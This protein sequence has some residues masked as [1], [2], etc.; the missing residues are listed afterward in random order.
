MNYTTP[1]R[2]GEKV[3][4]LGCGGKKLPGSTGVDFCEESD[5]DVIWDLD[6][7]PYPF[8]DNS[9]DRV[10]AEHVLEHVNNYLPAIE[11][12][13]RIL[14]PGGVLDVEVPYF[15][16]VFAFSD[17]THR[18][19]YTSRSFDYFVRGT[20]VFDFHYSTAEFKKREVRIVHGRS[21]FLANWVSNWI[22]N[23]LDTYEQR[24]AFWLPRHTLRFSLEVVKSDGK[25]EGA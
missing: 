12:I 2:E 18:R 11:E 7:T 5:A 8:E 9:W 20:P 17:P 1:V 14:K 21:G 16:S 6:K 13:H 19:F 3:L 23:H 15:S 24:L 10:V 25:G 4:H 22:N